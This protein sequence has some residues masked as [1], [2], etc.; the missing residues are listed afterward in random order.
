[1]TKERNGEVGNTG[2]CALVVKRQY[3]AW[4]PTLV[5]LR[6]VVVVLVLWL[7]SA[8]ATAQTMAVSQ[9]NAGPSPANSVAG[10][11]RI[12]PQF[13]D[14]WPFSEGLARVKQNGK[15]GFI[16]KAGALAIPPSFEEAESFSEDL[17]RVKQNGKWGFIDRAGKVVVAPGYQ[18]ARRFTEGL[19]AVTLDGKWGFIDKAGSIVIP[20]TFKSAR[21][22]T[23]G[24]AAV[25]VPWGLGAFQYRYVDRTGAVVIK[26]VGDEY[27]DWA[28]EFSEGRAIVCHLLTC[29]MIDKTGKIVVDRLSV[30]STLLLGFSEGR[31]AFLSA[32]DKFLGSEV[33]TRKVG[34]LDTNGAIVLSPSFDQSSLRMEYPSQQSVVHPSQMQK[35]V[36][37]EGLAAVEQDGKWG[38]IDKAG[39]MAIPATFYRAHRFSEGLAVVIDT[40]GYR[41]RGLTRRS[42]AV[43]VYGYVDKTGTLVIGPYVLDDWGIKLKEASEG[44]APV[45]VNGK[46][47]YASRD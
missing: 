6:S 8:A 1:M 11:M 12:A 47:G 19:A 16:D 39:A 14:A 5:L 4:G 43:G 34:F 33:P 40:T 42:G 32:K 18:D 24:L 23:D 15:W 22:F 31:S 37:S 36:F 9:A 2:Q 28:S 21:V 13:D 3:K 45:V 29:R 46:W 25:T 17:A 7:S 26:S 30:S 10:K 27:F 20:P 35:F 44:L 41:Q 38:F